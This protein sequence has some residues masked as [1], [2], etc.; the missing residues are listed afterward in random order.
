MKKV[1]YMDNQ[2]SGSLGY[3]NVPVG[4]MFQ[5]S[6]DVIP[7]GYLLCDGSAIS[8]TDYAALFAVIGTT[9]GS[10]DG[11]TT[12]NIPD[13]RGKFAEGADPT[14]ILGATGGE[15]EVTLSTEQMP[16][17]SHTTNSQSTSTTGGMSANESHSHGWNGY[18]NA[19][20]A[21]G[22]TYHYAIF[23]NDP[24]TYSGGPQPASVAH[25]HSF[26]HTHGT[27][28]KGGNQ[29][30]NNLPPYLNVNYIIKYAK[31]LVQAESYIDDDITTNANVWSAQNTVDNFSIAR[32]ISIGTATNLNTIT[33]DGNYWTATDAIANACTNRPLTGTNIYTFNLE[34]ST[35]GTMTFQKLSCT[36]GEFFR[37]LHNGTWS[38]W[39]MVSNTVYST[40]ERAIGTWIDGSVI[41]RKSYHGTG[42]FSAVTT[43]DSTLKP[44]N[45]KIINIYGS[46]KNK[47]DG[48]ILPIG[49]SGGSDISWRVDT[50]SGFCRA[51]GGYTT[52]EYWVTIEY[53]K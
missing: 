45:C 17:H 3:E 42:T 51:N 11:S 18:V 13:M 4:T 53:I 27:D 23:G 39:A 19:G 21:S 8:R 48:N 43:I 40:T 29:P 35:K 5:F 37:E 46:E 1:M 24:S 33:T 12:F 52:S 7:V 9:Y 41:Y 36:S 22:S 50:S 30:H 20:K 15:A 25:I 14:H 47:S 2:L 44:N 49:Y 10:G 34:V 31:T 38:N 6:S 26:A 28:S 32:K 16:S